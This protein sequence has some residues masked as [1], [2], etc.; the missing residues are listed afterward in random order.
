MC[1]LN[2]AGGN[3]CT[4]ALSLSLKKKRGVALLKLSKLFFRLLARTRTQ[5]EL[6]K[7]EELLLL[8]KKMQFSRIAFSVLSLLA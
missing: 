2:F 3:S 4:F 5:I 8:A 1:G 6:S 7:I